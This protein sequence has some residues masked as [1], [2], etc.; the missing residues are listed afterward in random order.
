MEEFVKRDGEKIENI[1]V[2]NVLRVI[3]K[4]EIVV[5]VTTELKGIA[6]IS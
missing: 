5:V 6:N 3:L 2:A 1:Y 4:N